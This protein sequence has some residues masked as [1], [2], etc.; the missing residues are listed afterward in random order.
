MPILAEERGQPRKRSRAPLWIAAGV[1]AVLLG[2]VALLP[3]TQCYFEV[4]PVTIDCGRFGADPRDLGFGVPAGFHPPRGR[5]NNY[6][7]HMGDWYW[8]VWVGP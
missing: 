2:R 5:R 6:T 8:T 1:L 4:G 3:L 7:F